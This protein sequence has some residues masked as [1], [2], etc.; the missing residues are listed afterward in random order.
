MQS[1]MYPETARALLAKSREFTQP[2][3]EA[4]QIAEVA[5]QFRRIG[6]NEQAAQELAEIQ[7]RGV[8]S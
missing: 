8:Q 6:W 7:V 5:E 4:R 2:R 1:F 3:R